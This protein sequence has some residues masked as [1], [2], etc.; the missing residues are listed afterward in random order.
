MRP[1]NVMARPAPR[2]RQPSRADLVK[3]KDAAFSDARSAEHRADALAA[4]IKRLEGQLTEVRGQRDSL[5]RDASVFKARAERAE[6]GQQALREELAGA[7]DK[8][9][10][11]R[12]AHA[13]LEQLRSHLHAIFNA[14]G[15]RPERKDGMITPDDLERMRDSIASAREAARHAGEREAK[16][17]IAK[18][19]ATVLKKVNE[20]VGNATE[21]AF[22]VAKREA[23][24]HF[25]GPGGLDIVKALDVNERRAFWEAAADHVD[26]PMLADA[27]RGYMPGGIEDYDPQPMTHAIKKGG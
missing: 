1:P 22:N 4:D 16:E 18:A 9:E 12:Q 20:A 11:A 10:H 3:L 8:P 19:N 23:T 14:I 26:D 17:I 2:T 24:E 15:M 25:C 21:H 6:R 13:A 5:A 7:V 27:M